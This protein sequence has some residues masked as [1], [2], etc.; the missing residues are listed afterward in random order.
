MGNETLHKI[1]EYIALNYANPKV[2]FSLYN[3]EETQ[4]QEILEDYLGKC[5][6]ALKDCLD[7]VM[8]GKNKFDKNNSARI[9]NMLNHYMK[10]MKKPEAR[11]WLYFQP[12]SYTGK[13]SIGIKKVLNILQQARVTKRGETFGATSWSSML[14][15]MK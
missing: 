7:F 13:S 11:A 15:T 6:S 10:F 9:V 2:E 3:E 8:D 5:S 4:P 1:E 12:F 14:L